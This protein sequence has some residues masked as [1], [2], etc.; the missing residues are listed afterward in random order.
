MVWSY[1]A[2]DFGVIQKVYKIEDDW[3]IKDYEGNVYNFDDVTDDGLVFDPRKGWYQKFY[4][5][6]DILIIRL[7]AVEI[8]L[9]KRT[10]LLDKSTVKEGESIEKN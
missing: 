5:K 10:L 2:Q 8:S 4:C 6:N 3:F 1:N 7:A 9:S